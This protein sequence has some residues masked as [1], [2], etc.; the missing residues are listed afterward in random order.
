[1]KFKLAKFHEKNGDLNTRWCVEYYFEHP[2]TYEMTRF[3]I[4]ISSRLKTRAERR[5]KGDML[6]AE[7]NKKLKQGWNPFENNLLLVKSL[8][9]AFDHV[10]LI[11]KSICR[12]RTYRDY[13]SV[14]NFF[15]DYTESIGRIITP[16]DVSFTIALNYLEWIRKQN[17][18]TNR[19][20]NN[21]LIYLKSAFNILVEREYTT[22]NPFL[23]I[24]KF[25]IEQ[26]GIL[27]FNENET[28]LISETLP[29]YNR[30]LYIISLMIYYCFLRPQEIC[31]LRLYNI[32]LKHKEIM[33]FAHMSKNKKQ[34]SV[35]IP[36][37][38]YEE[39]MACELHK[40]PSDNYFCSKEFY[41][42]EIEIAPTRI[43][44][45]WRVYA[46]SVGLPVSKKIY[47]LKHTGVGRAVDKG[48]NLR[49]IQLQIRHSSLDIT[50]KYLRQFRTKVSSDFMNKMPGL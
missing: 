45:A 36:E 5:R 10:L 27:A 49:D 21:H 23:K 15:A 35:G 50:E 22:F 48:I 26:P 4:W 44:E 40:Y 2:E 32:D 38:L 3:I 47:H 17:K 14:L 33:V 12:K 29:G 42:G 1:M 28:K 37:I 6:V 39:L 11:K 7:I 18:L 9:E 19:S 20:I 30:R 13:K 25:E 31:R 16:S 34:E 41:P 24:K 46:N 8:R 43:A